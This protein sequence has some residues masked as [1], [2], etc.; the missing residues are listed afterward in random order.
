M[1]KVKI[2]L[3]NI[4]NRNIKFWGKHIDKAKYF[5]H[6]KEIFENLD[7]RLQDGSIDLTIE[8]LP[9]ILECYQDIKKLYL[10]VTN[11]NHAQ[12]TYRGGR[13]IQRLLQDKYDIEL[14]EINHNPTIRHSCF[15][16]VKWF[17]EEHKEFRKE[18]YELI[19]SGSWGIPAMKEALNFLG[20]VGYY[21][22]VVDVNETTRIVIPG[23]V[24]LEY[25]K[26]FQ[27]KTLCE[28]ITKYDYAGAVTFIKE[29]LIYNPV[30]EKVC[31]Y[32]S[33]RYNFDFENARK[34][35]NEV[36][37]IHKNFVY[38][39]YDD[40]DFLIAE[41]L[42]N[43][44]ISFKKWE[45]A[46]VVAKWH[47]LSEV[48]YFYLF[49]KITKIKKDDIKEIKKL[50][51]NTE[52]NSTKSK[53][54]VKW[55]VLMEYLIKNYKNSNAEVWFTDNITKEIF[56]YKEVRNNAMIAHGLGWVAKNDAENLLKNL[57]SYKKEMYPNNIN[58]FNTLNKLLIS[59]IQ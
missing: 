15:E 24:T 17:L 51:I 12:D 3:A 31:L 36:K 30:F 45:Y 22:T 43:I 50:W 32:L 11:Q 21:S 8:I 57:L 48:L 4:G 16:F 37:S 23:S 29:S 7:E 10:F 40:T 47:A 34:Y 58:I 25:M 39:N 28:M 46:N 14:V 44:E 49:E 26:S 27:K 13:I 18:S 35:H 20:S 41:L 53:E 54:F 56:Q 38:E 5:E 9:E 6:S 42:E 19:I 59:K 55:F 33:F 52:Y 1:S 2:L